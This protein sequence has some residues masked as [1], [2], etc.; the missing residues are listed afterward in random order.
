MITTCI[1]HATPPSRLAAPHQATSRFRPDARAGS[2]RRCCRVRESCRRAAHRS[3]HRST[4]PQS[5]G[6]VRANA[7]DCAF[8][9]TCVRGRDAT[10]GCR[11]APSLPRA[12]IGDAAGAAHRRRGGV[13]PD[14]S[15]SSVGALRRVRRANRAGRPAALRPARLRHRARPA[16]HQRGLHDRRI[17]WSRHAR[18]CRHDRHSKLAR[19]RRDAAR[20]AARRAP[21]HHA[22]GMGAI[23]GRP[24]ARPWAPG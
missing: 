2:M 15:F 18:S 24:R 6:S 13:R 14:Q 4:A 8:S 10:T 3:M 1:A 19:W 16:R 9:I 20:C 12:K 23:S 22:L 21:R 7:F 11:S 17:A 5:A